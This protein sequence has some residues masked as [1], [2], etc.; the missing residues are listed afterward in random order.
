[1]TIDEYRKQVGYLSHEYRVA[2]KRARGIARERAE[3][4]F[5]KFLK[6]EKA[7]ALTNFEKAK[8]ELSDRYAIS[9]TPPIKKKH[10]IGE[11]RSLPLGDIMADMETEEE[12]DPLAKL[13]YVELMALY[14]EGKITAAQAQEAISKQKQ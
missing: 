2:K 3:I 10:T 9:K 5:Q 1:M 11:L 4:E 8:A 7:R 13:T 12:D 14:Q 6:E